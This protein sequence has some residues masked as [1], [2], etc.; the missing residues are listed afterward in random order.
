MMM[1]LPTSS[2]RSSLYKNVTMRPM[3]VCVCLSA[4]CVLLLCVPKSFKIVK[5]RLIKAGLA[6]ARARVHKAFSE[7]SQFGGPRDR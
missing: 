3:C 4:D 5:S 1:M 2:A 6:C 7:T